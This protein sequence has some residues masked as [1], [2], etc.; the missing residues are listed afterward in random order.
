M[1]PS[2]GTPKRAASKVAAAGNE[3][4]LDWD[5]L[6]ALSET[7]RRALRERAGERLLAAGAQILLDS[8]LDLPQNLSG[9]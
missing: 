2:A 5:T 8:V 4:G 9:R 7:E 6:W 1:S 3:V